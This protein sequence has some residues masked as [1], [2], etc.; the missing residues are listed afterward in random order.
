MQCGNYKSHSPCK[1]YDSLSAVMD[2]YMNEC[3]NIL[4]GNI[5]AKITTSK[6]YIYIVWDCVKNW[7]GEQEV[8]E[9]KDNQEKRDGHKGHEEPEKN[10]E[11]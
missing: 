11:E 8:H 1:N 6:D 7:Q 4:G 3:I 2:L 9:K 10:C 5:T